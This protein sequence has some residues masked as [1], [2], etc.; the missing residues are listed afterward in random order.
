MIGHLRK[1]PCKREVFCEYLSKL[2][3]LKSNHFDVQKALGLPPSRRY[4]HTRH[5]FGLRYKLAY[6]LWRKTPGHHRAAVR[7]TV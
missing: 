5:K 4:D 1:K 6:A 3:A 7:L 2:R